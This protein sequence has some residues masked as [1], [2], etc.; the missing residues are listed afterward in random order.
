MLPQGDLIIDNRGTS[1]NDSSTPL[2]AIGSG[3][4][5]A[6]TSTSLTNSS[7][8]WTAGALKG[9]QVNP[10][11][12]Q[13]TTFTVV[14]NTATTLYID[15]ANGD[16]T[17][18]SVAGSAYT[19]V[20]HFN[21]MSV[22][23]TSKVRCN[24]QVAADSGLTIDGSGT[25]LVT[26]DVR[27]NTITLT[28]GGVLTH[29]NTTATTTYSLNLNATTLLAIDSSSKIDV[30]G[31]GYLGGSS[32]GNS[33]TTGMT[34]GNTA[35]GGSTQT[36]STGNGGSYGGLGGIYSGGSVNTVYGDLMNPG[37]VG[38]GGGAGA[39]CPYYCSSQPGGNGGGLVKI[40]AGALQ[41][42][43][44]IIAD[45][46]AGTATTYNG[47][48]G[49]GGGVNLHVS[50][51]SGTGMIAA[52]GG[53]GP[54]GAG[55][56]GRIAVYYDTLT[57]PTGNFMASGGKSASQNN[58]SYNGGAGTIYLKSNSLLMPD[59]IINNG[60]VNTSRATPIS[61]SVYQASNAVVSGGAVV[62]YI[63]P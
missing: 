23:G 35:S 40:T 7:A 43:G 6:V 13:A 61:N 17:Q 48:G 28:N 38:S 4:I 60:G 20:Y 5:S 27:A 53:A 56:G 16:L 37:E 18:V 14:D 51:L 21:S 3:V 12:N 26:G 46:G 36:S 63:N 58:S 33:S 25:T 47:G 15:P 42:D 30:T 2:R 24:D 41:V 34:Y 59:L 31:R 1:S 45:G 54:G 44:S 49:S 22:L 19:G 9:M 52:R 39:Y 8:A 57:L 11:T 29:G 32:G 55:G 50:T 10:N 62:T